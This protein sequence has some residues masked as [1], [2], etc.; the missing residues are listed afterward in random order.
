M[1]TLITD[2]YR[3]A[4]H[5][6]YLN[7]QGSSSGKWVDMIFGMILSARSLHMKDRFYIRTVLD[8]GCGQGQM[9]QG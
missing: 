1:A 8:Y 9:K 4:C 6:L 7:G 2:G 5:T 3:E